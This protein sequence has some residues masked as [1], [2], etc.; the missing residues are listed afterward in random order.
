M[1]VQLEKLLPVF[2]IPE[3][4]ISTEAS[5]YETMY[6]RYGIRNVGRMGSPVVSPLSEWDMSKHAVLHYMP[7]HEKDFGMADNYPLLNGWNKYTYVNHI[8]DLTQTLGNPRPK[9][10]NFKLAIRAYRKLYPTLKWCRDERHFG[11]LKDNPSVLLVM[12]Y[13]LMGRNWRYRPIPMIEVMQWSNT[14]DTL[15]KNVEKVATITDR[16]Q[17]LEVEPPFVLPSKMEL[18]RSTE[19]LKRVHMK[20]FD[21][22]KKLDLLDLWRWMNPSTRKLS[23]LGL[24]SDKH[25]LYVNFVFRLSGNFVI[26]NL[27]RLNEWILGHG[28]EELEE[29]KEDNDQDDET[30]MYVQMQKRM[31]KFL[32][33]LN[34]FRKEENTQVVV[35]DINKQIEYHLENEVDVDIS[36]D[37]EEEQVNQTKEV[38]L[39]ADNPPDVKVNPETEEVTT[40]AP[41][42][43]PVD[44]VI[45]EKDKETGKL[46]VKYLN[47]VQRQE[48]ALRKDKLL[49]QIEQS[50][51]ENIKLTS[52]LKDE[53]VVIQKVLKK[54]VVEELHEEKTDMPS[55]RDIT[56]PS[57][58]EVK[59]TSNIHQQAAQL[60]KTAMM[61]QGEMK[62][63]EGMAN[64]FKK[65][66][67]PYG[68]GRSLEEV[69]SEE[70][71]IVDEV[72][73][74]EIPDMPLVTD[75]TMLKSRNVDFDKRYIKHVMSRD[76]ARSVLAVQKAGVAVTSYEK[77]DLIDAGNEFERHSIQV[78]P[79]GGA[80]S[81][82][83]VKVPKIREDGSFLSG[84]VR[85]TLKK[86]RVDRPIRKVNDNKVALTS[87]YGKV[88]MNRSDR[89]KYNFDKWL[90]NQIELSVID[91][92]FDKISYGVSSHPDMDLPRE[93]VVLCTRYRSLRIKERGITLHLDA[94]RPSDDKLFIIGKDQNGDDIY[95]DRL[96]NMVQYGKESAIEI[97]ELLGLDETKRPVDYSEIGVLGEN[98]P[99]GLI[100][101]RHYG[102]TELCKKLNV[103]PV[104]L[105]RGQHVQLSPSQWSIKFGDEIWIFPKENRI[106]SLIL[107]GLKK[108]ESQIKELPAASF[109]EKDVYGS[110][111]AN[112][113]LHI[114]YEYELDLMEQMFVDDI[115]EHLLEKMH[116]P[117]TFPEL[118]IR[119][120]EMLLT[121]YIPTEINMD[122]MLI[123]GYERIPGA[124][125][126]ELVKAARA[127]K[128]KPITSKRRFEIG[129]N[130]I[131]LA[132]QKDPSLEIVDEI[133]PLKNM[134]EKDIV[135]FG[136]V[137]GRSR[138]SMTRPTRSYHKTDLGTISE[139]T[140][141]NQD[142]GMTTFLSASP[143]FTDLYG[144]TERVDNE[145]I[146][147]AEILSS[148]A[149]TAPAADLDDQK[150]LA[151]V[152]IQAE[153]R[154]PVKGAMPVPVRTGYENVV[155][156]KVSKNFAFPAEQDGKV[157][158]KKDNVV[159]IEYKDGS[160]TAIQYGLRMASSKGH[161]YK[162]VLVCDYEEGQTF[163][164]GDILVFNQQFFL[165]DIL[166]PGQVVQVNYVL[167]ATA[168]VD[169]EET[170]E[171]GCC[172]S[173]YISD[174][175]TTEAVHLKTVLTDV[176]SNIRDMV[177]V[178]DHVDLDDILCIIED[179]HIEATHV[180][181]DEAS[182]ILRRLGAYTPKAG[183]VGKVEKIEAFYF[184]EYEDMS[185]S[186]KAV[187]T[188]LDTARARV[189]S[190]TRDG[191]ASTGQLSE[192]TRMNGEMISQGK[193]LFKFY[194]SHDDGMSAG[195]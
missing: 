89:G 44:N 166:N 188:P 22:E 79:V 30:T 64:A 20:I 86:Q 121:G 57:H 59:Y 156:H 25:L 134:K 153:H 117:T 179:Q 15:W 47:P 23:K 192:S 136:G 31:L 151:F 74:V 143:R 33:L 195:D 184:A 109:E 194:I 157:L 13:G 75:K 38:V 114:R 149:M 88:F 171:D 142:V 183:F 42:I 113:G 55:E 7:S 169:F 175:L 39:P 51:A 63:I 120:S 180:Y 36:D 46:T 8:L 52:K 159:T 1:E 129:P 105:E 3:T 90:L 135:T 73:E 167:A 127:H 187:V 97:G 190:K 124:V 56:P 60:V 43:A 170:L 68:S 37:E 66:K 50:H 92:K 146:T 172:V 17:F 93:L 49:Q 139:G 95:F 83:H 101:A 54:D 6:R 69:V 140:V 112:E 106:A 48:I 131:W 28:V 191:S 29:D 102:I 126:R 182:D 147:S 152:G 186:I 155:A 122:D 177:K 26:L 41:P 99:V 2:V 116:E 76:M 108:Y 163:K 21:D 158:T 193:V 130:D 12:N 11:L 148:V 115:T 160:K 19:E 168:L 118:L 18:D 100:L 173:E 162:H 107:G 70:L 150:R 80:T 132:I 144:N 67:D 40:V 24:V 5:L 77:E 165:R 138:R 133:N 119:G 94:I 9:L 110:L 111:L 178:G 154:I 174:Q 181:D 61:T 98:I 32:K 14:R 91:G 85:Y 27:G 4:E 10:F 164:K 104:K 125:Y 123:K 137:G 78:T 34:E 62:R 145:D 45:V 189:V 65:I 71:A 141:D 81:T 82:I 103:Q 53:D 72:P 35:T 176:T 58:I 96:T 16:Q 128:L 87:Y 84:N 161:Y 185:D